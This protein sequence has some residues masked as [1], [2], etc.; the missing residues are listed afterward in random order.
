M[1]SGRRR[2]PIAWIALLGGVVLIAA[3]VLLWRGN[4][5]AP[6]NAGQIPA[7]ASAQPPTS[8]F[9]L[10][11]A[12]TGTKPAPSPA[13]NSQSM[14]PIKA[15]PESAVVAPPATVDPE[16]PVA[17]DN[18]IDSS[19]PVGPQNTGA[20]ATSAQAGAP[21]R[22]D[23][24]AIGV[25]ATVQPVDSVNGVLGVPDDIGRVGW[26]RH[27]ALPGSATGTTVLDGHIDSAVDG[28]GALFHLGNVNPGDIITITTATGSLQYRVQARHVYVKAQGLPADLFTQE[29]P[30]RLVIISC[31]G[32]FDS[33]ERSYR[34]NIAIYATPA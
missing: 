3:A 16:K 10:I 21:T 29:G 1:G 12:T 8:K 28:E 11:S 27:S 9:L 24:P 6:T 15:A 19:K 20:T 32:T 33:A 34:D 5:A 13:A 17:T 26:W 18:A 2:S 25:A 23:L 22:L 30:P 14:R 7:A 31:G 4:V